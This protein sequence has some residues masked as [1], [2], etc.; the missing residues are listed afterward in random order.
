MNNISTK[1]ASN[2]E[3]RQQREIVDYMTKRGMRFVAVPVLNDADFL[4]LS[5]LVR[6]RLDALEKQAEKEKNESE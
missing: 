1:K 6:V 3:M 2:L 5:S 4:Y